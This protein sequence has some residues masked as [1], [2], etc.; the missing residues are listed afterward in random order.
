[1]A[2]GPDDATVLGWFRFHPATATT[3]P[4]HDAIRQAFRATA[5]NLLG[6]LP[7]GPDRTLALRKF[8]EAMM[9]ANACLANSQTPEEDAQALNPHSV[10][11]PPTP[12]LGN[13]ARE[14]V[15]SLLA[16]GMN[17]TEEQWSRMVTAR[18]ALA[19]LID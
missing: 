6:F 15:D 18:D 7:E 16:I 5:Q 19:A 14:L 11:A 4:T 3:G 8:Q 2:T 10:D 12:T 9:F 1:M 13:T 17:P